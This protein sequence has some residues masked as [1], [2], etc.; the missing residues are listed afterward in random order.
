[1][2]FK[3]ESGEVYTLTENLGLGQDTDTSNT[4]DF[5]LHVWVAIGVAQVC[6]MGTPGSV[7]CITL[8]DDGILV[9]SVCQCE[10]RLRFL[11]GV[12]IIRL[13][14]A[15]PVG[16]RSPDVWGMFSMNDVSGSVCLT[17]YDYV[18]VM[19]HKIFQ[20]GERSCLDIDISPVHP[21]M[22]GAERGT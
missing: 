13:F 10:C 15:E 2:L 8:H 20:N 4:V 17:W 22:G 1:M 7:L 21:A 14:S 6:Q 9:Q 16:Q 12:Q 3:T 18:F 5:H 11:P 19:A